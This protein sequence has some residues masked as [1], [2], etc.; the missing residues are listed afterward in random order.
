LNGAPWKSSLEE[1]EVATTNTPHRFDSCFDTKTI[2]FIS[3][4]QKKNEPHLRCTCQP[5]MARDATRRMRDGTRRKNARR[6][7]SRKTRSAALN[8]DMQWKRRICQQT[9]AMSLLLATTA[10]QIT[11][12]TWVLQSILREVADGDDDD[13]LADSCAAV[14]I[15]AVGTVAQHAQIA[16]QFMDVDAALFQCPHGQEPRAHCSPMR[17]RRIDNFLLTRMHPFQPPV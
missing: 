10:L 17:C 9:I 1:F 3:Q 13:M 7:T 6:R 15:A 11:W 16:D 2:D 4:Q 14:S 8:A 5:N 12:K